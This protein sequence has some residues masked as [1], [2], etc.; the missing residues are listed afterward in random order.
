M[1]E[2]K[3]AVLARAMGKLHSVPAFPDRVIV[4]APGAYSTELRAI[5]D[6]HAPNYGGHRDVHI[7]SAALGRLFPVAAI[8]R[9]PN[10]ILSFPQKWPVPHKK[11]DETGVLVSARLSRVRLVH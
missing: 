5:N 1:G 3:C 6:V 10:P 7:E 8:V 11:G 9:W 4:A 2:T